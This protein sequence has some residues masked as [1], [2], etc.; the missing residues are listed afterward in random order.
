MS[1]ADT[2][3][4]RP[5]RSPFWASLR[6]R[7]SSIS[8]IAPPDE[9]SRR[10]R[11]E[12]QKPQMAPPAH[13]PRA[14]RQE[15]HH[16]PTPVGNTRCRTGRPR[17]S[18]RRSRPAAIAGPRQQPA[19]HRPA[20]PPRQPRW[21]PPP[22]R[23]RTRTSQGARELSAQTPRPAS[24]PAEKGKESEADTA[25]PLAT[26]HPD[27]RRQHGRRGRSQGPGPQRRTHWHRHPPHRSGAA[28]KPPHSERAAAPPPKSG[29]ERSG[30]GGRREPCHDD[31]AGKG[32]R[33]GPQTPAASASSER[34]A[35]QRAP[36]GSRQRHTAEAAGRNQGPRSKQTTRSTHKHLQRPHPPPA[37][38]HHPLRG[39]NPK[40]R[41]KGKKEKKHLIR[42]RT[43][44]SGIGNVEGTQDVRTR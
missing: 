22:T 39:R 15:P 28:G 11:R 27:R 21:R 26:P 8:I 36:P 3:A 10:R 40:K 9:L 37:P 13:T 18:A 43:V 34:G 44:T 23:P 12:G 7:F 20:A 29:G 31:G 25:H 33:R 38:P 32:A 17:A 41:K 6:A 24:R 4:M 30:R 16:P 1:A 35:D 42:E 2:Q 5:A 19:Q 14:A